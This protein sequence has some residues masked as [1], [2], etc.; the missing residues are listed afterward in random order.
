MLGAEVE[1]YLLDTTVA[2]AAW[3]QGNKVYSITRTRLQQLDQDRIFISCITIAEIEYGLKVAPY[4]DTDR[5]DNVRQAMASYKVLPI[6]KHTAESYSDIRAALFTKYSPRDR[7]GR[8]TTKY[9]EDLVEP[10]TGK[11]LGIQENDLWIVSVARQYNLVFVTIDRG[12]GMQRVIE[13]AGY[14]Q[15]TQ[16]W[17]TS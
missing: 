17:P 13:G 7:R 11:E 1:V 8:M 9:I 3:D 5:Q 4:I 12:G 16:Y 6:D 10:T 2:S 14:S 15:R